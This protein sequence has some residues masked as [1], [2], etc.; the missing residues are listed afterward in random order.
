MAKVNGVDADELNAL[1]E[2]VKADPGKGHVEFN[3]KTH[4]IDGAHSKTKI[5]NFTVESDEPEG[6]LGSNMAPNPVELV[7]AS[8]GS[9]L[10]V[11]FAYN[12]AVMGITILSL[13]ID[14]K[15]NLDLRGF[16]GISDRVRPGYQKIA[17]TCKIDSNATGEQLEKLC[18]YVR[19]T[20]PVADI[21]GNSESLEILLD[22]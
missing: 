15:G 19:D 1:V 20:S 4:W 17:V 18:K 11:G 3:T 16:F 22:R 9:C 12:A 8:L 14:I 10:A 7:L 2:A 21:V 13:D 6:L 5:R